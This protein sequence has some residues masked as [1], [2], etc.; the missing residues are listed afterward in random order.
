ME[1]QNLLALNVHA[2]IFVLFSFIIL[3]LVTASVTHFF[4]RWYGGD[5]VNTASL[6]LG[7]RPQLLPPPLLCNPASRRIF[8]ITSGER[9]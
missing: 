4:T 8:L 2:C 6:F 7:L 1:R 3:I 9:R 5:L